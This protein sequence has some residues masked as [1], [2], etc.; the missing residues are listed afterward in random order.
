VFDFFFFSVFPVP[1][2]VFIFVFF[3]F[4]FTV[5]SFLVAP[6]CL[7]FIAVGK[8]VTESALVSGLV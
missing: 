3:P 1:F 6:R 2:H 8:G 4:R 7:Y 5:F